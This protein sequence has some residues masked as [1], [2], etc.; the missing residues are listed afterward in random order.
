MKSI[1]LLLL[2][3]GLAFATPLEDLASPSQRVRD[4]AAGELRK[5]F[6][7]PPRKAWDDLAASIKVGDTKASVMERLKPFNAKLGAGSGSGQTSNESYHLDGAWV[8]WVVFVRLDATKTGDEATTVTKV[9]LKEHLQH[10]WVEPP[11]GFTGMWTTYFVNGQR[12]HEVHYAGGS[13]SGQF[14]SFRSDG[15]K[16]CVQHY[17]PKGAE[18]EDTGYF[19]SGRVSYRGFHKEGKPVGTWT[20]YKEDGSVESTKEYPEQDE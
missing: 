9:S 7:V 14:T 5:S 6:V 3:S 1:A 18:G 17:G 16:A 19:P 20:H 15:S 11:E 4:G 10:I 13:Y 8:L 2:S 12:S